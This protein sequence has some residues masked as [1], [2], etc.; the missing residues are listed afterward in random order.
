[1]PT[2]RRS[3][4]GSEM[5]KHRLIAATAG[6][7]AAILLACGTSAFA[8]KPSTPGTFG[9]KP[10]KK[11]VETATAARDSDKETKP[12]STPVTSDEAKKSAPA[13]AAAHEPEKKA[14]I[15]TT[16]TRDQ[17]NRSTATTAARTRDLE[18]KPVAT[19]PSRSE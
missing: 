6:T 5:M 17:E 19:T 12:A 4:Q 1:T 13:T 7:V 8:Q 3:N 15:T 9:R 16:S 18:K 14:P 10:E 11:P 2:A